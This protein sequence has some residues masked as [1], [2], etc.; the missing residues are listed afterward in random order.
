M[1]GV[2]L[3]TVDTDLLAAQRRLA[4]RIHELADHLRGELIH[5]DVRGPHVR[6]PGV[7]SAPPPLGRDDLVGQVADRFVLDERF[8]Q[9]WQ[10]HRTS[11][12]RTQLEEHLRATLVDLIHDFLRRR[13][14][15][16][17]LVHPP[18]PDDAHHRDEP[19]D[20]QTDVLIHPVL[21]ELLDAFREPGL[22]FPFDH[23][24]AFHRQHDHAV[25]D[26]DVAHLPG[27]KQRL[28]FRVHT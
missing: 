12:A 22:R 24:R 9:R 4:K 17:V 1:H 21:I 13:K 20:E 25:L 18:L 3:D 10:D 11:R 16:G 5:L 8:Q 6:E 26:L 23:V 7:R 27:R 14:D 2:D 15:L 19:W 28:I